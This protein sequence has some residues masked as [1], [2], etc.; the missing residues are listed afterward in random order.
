MSLLYRSW[1]QVRGQETRKGIAINNTADRAPLSRAEVKRKGE[2]SK[3]CWQ[4]EQ[5][6]RR[7]GGPPGSH[8]F[9][10]RPCPFPPP[11]LL[12][13]REREPT[14]SGGQRGS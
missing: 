10:T 12:L 1:G 7:G 5:L 11:P 8:C 13:S 6:G 9:L 14:A 4:E 3:G 2:G